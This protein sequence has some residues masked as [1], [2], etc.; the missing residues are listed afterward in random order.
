[1]KKRKLLLSIVMATAVLSFSG[2]AVTNSLQSVN[3]DVEEDDDDEEAENTDEA[4]ADADTDGDGSDEGSSTRS[5]SEGIQPDDDVIPGDAQYYNADGT[6]KVIT[7]TLTMP[8]EAG[9]ETVDFV[10]GNYC[11]IEFE[12][13]YAS[14]HPELVK[15]VSDTMLKESDVK[16]EMAELYGYAQEMVADSGDDYWGLPYGTEYGIEVLRWDDSMFVYRVS[17]YGWS[18]GAHG[19]GSSTFCSF[20]V[21]TG[22]QLDVMD[23]IT[24][25]SELGESI[26]N[27][28]KEEYPDN[29]E[30]VNGEEYFS[31]FDTIRAEIEDKNLDC[32]VYGD[33][34][35]VNFDQYEIASYAAGAFEVTLTPDECGN[36]IMDSCLPDNTGVLSQIVFYDNLEVEVIE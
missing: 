32:A 26:M 20:D 2:C 5:A 15:A 13:E 3:T 4:E 10:T 31:P 9:G 6:V 24:D 8:G 17:T 25:P 36:V 29:D 19:F 1:M 12:P 21:A 16:D 7:H 14:A 35:H 34:L 22:E 23:F 28:L 33:G 18:G 27:K 30:I 11:E